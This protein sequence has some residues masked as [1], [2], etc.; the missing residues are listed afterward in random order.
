MNPV[1]FVIADYLWNGEVTGSGVFAVHPH[2]Y[3]VI[4][5]P[6]PFST[7]GWIV[8]L[9]VVLRTRVKVCWGGSG[10]EG[11]GQHGSL[12][13]QGYGARLL[14]HWQL[15]ARGEASRGV[16]CFLASDGGKLLQLR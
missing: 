3:F 13:P 1:V 10:Y 16:V 8:V 4:R 9:L 14:P 5:I 6:Y 15:S 11:Q 12:S 7:P 2:T